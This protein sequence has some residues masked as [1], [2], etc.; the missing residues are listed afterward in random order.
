[1][2]RAGLSKNVFRIYA[3]WSCVIDHTRTNYETFYFRAW[4]MEIHL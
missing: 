3:K 1:M 2:K 4:A